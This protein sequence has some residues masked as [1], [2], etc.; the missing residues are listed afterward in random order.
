[1]FEDTEFAT[2]TKSVAR[3]EVPISFLSAYTFLATMTKS[4][5]EKEVGVQGGVWKPP[6][7]AMFFVIVANRF[8]CVQEDDLQDGIH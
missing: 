7:L 1:L 6:S 8:G 4:V 3:K 2:M 5:A